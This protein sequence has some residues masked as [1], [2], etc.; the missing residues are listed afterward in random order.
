MND[1]TLISKDSNGSAKNHADNNELQ[2]SED[3]IMANE[4][5]ELSGDSNFLVKDFS[6]SDEFASQLKTFGKENDVTTFIVAFAVLNALFFRYNN[7]EEINAGLPF[8]TN[9]ENNGDTKA[10]LFKGFWPLSKKVTGNTTF[11]ELLNEIKSA[12]GSVTHEKNIVRAIAE[13]KNPDRPTSEQDTVSQVMLLFDN[14]AEDQQMQFGVLQLSGEPLA[15]NIGRPQM[16]FCIKETVDGCKGSLEYCRSIFSNEEATRIVTHFAAL[17]SSAIKEPSQKIFELGILKSEEKE[18]LLTGFNSSSANYSR[19][20]TIVDLFEEQALTNPGRIAIVFENRRINYEELNKRSNQLAHYLFNRG[21]KKEALIPI[22]LER[23]WEMIVAILGILKA[24]AAYVPIDPEYPQ[25][26][27]NYMLEDT[28]AAIVISKSASAKKLN[29]SA[30]LEVIELDSQGEAIAKMSHKN[31][32]SQITSRNLAYI[33]YTSGSTGKPKGVMIEHQAVLDHCF[34]LIQTAELDSC[35]SFALFSPL[36]FDAGHSV[37]FVS[38]F[39]GASLNVLSKDLIMDGEKLVEHFNENPVDF[40]KIVPSVWLSYI[41]AGNKVLAQKIMLFGGESFTPK[42]K[43]HLIN[44]EYKGIVYNHY[45][46]TEATI[47]KCIH[48]VNLQRNYKTMPIGKPFSNTQLYVVDQYEKIVP[49]GVSGELYIAGEGIARGYLNRPELSAEKFTDDTFRE[50]STSTSENNSEDKIVSRLY[51]TGDKVRWNEDGEIEYLGRIDEQ[52]KLRGHRIELGEIENV[53]LQD[54]QIRQAAV[55]LAEDNYGNKLLVG[56]IV[57]ESTFDKSA[58]VKNVQKQLPEYMVPGFWVQLKA[59]PLTSNGKIDKKALPAP[60]VSGVLDSQYAAPETE[61]EI[62]LAKM[63]EDLLGIKK[64]GVHD[65]FFELGGNSIQTVTMFTRIRKHFGKELPLPTIFQAPNIKKLAAIITEKDNAVNFSCLIPIQPLGSKIPLFCMHAG[66]GNVLFYKDLAKNLGN[67][68]PLYGLMAR[69]LLGKEHFHTSIEEMAAHYIKEI[70]SVQPHG[71]YLFAG[72][73]LGGTLAFEM[74]KQLTDAGEK[75]DLLATFNSR[76]STYLKQR[77]TLSFSEMIFTYA[78]DYSSMKKKQKILYPIRVLKIGSKLTGQIFYRKTKNKILTL[79]V[80][81]TM[82][83]FD[84]YLSRGK[85]LP[86]FLRNRYLLHTNGIMAREY[87]PGIYTGKM[88]IFKSPHIYKERYLGWREHIAGEIEVFNVPGKYKS[89][90]KI[91]NEPYVKVISDKL[92]TY[93]DPA[94]QKA[95]GEKKNRI[96]SV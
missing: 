27:I 42:I 86:R 73:C 48:T 17:L 47:G 69:G 38:L 63:W 49:I 24:G 31:L 9:A 10:M 64:V 43:E 72:Y 96:A 35:R 6:F 54:P 51:K 52:V 76:S 3:K 7:E 74:A 89:R 75:V 46:P 39:L 21:V 90:D 57:P 59:L 65:T 87:E 61:T 12:G 4:N 85:L 8:G 14:T 45:G 78:G 19:Q 60:D 29:V 2:I 95:N 20:K 88:I 44:L 33:I 92:K 56:Y 34:G 28:A 15:I 18:Q 83:G 50:E 53:L 22:C 94:S 77:K 37:I 68:Q 23:S 91:M 93:L 80:K 62:A 40:I 84:Y 81:A 67:D 70:Q 41:N 5:S 58:T 82:R 1:Y 30:K 32:P 66:A 79:Y 16:T 25:D 71:P 11:I 55:K 26:R 36:V 13:P